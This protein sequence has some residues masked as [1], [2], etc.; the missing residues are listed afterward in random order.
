MC[1]HSLP[2]LLIRL[3]QY[4]PLTSAMRKGLLWGVLSSKGGLAYHILPKSQNF[5]LN[6]Q[7]EFCYLKDKSSEMVMLSPVLGL[8]EVL[9][10]HHLSL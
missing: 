2:L 9:L 7:T 10:T 6:V 3:G 5:L 4:Q 8:V 1:Q